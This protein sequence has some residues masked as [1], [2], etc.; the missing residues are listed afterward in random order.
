[1]LV[2]ASGDVAAPEVGLPFIESSPTSREVFPA[3]GGRRSPCSS[4]L[5]VGAPPSWLAAR[6]TSLGGVGSGAA[7]LLSAERAELEGMPGCGVPVAASAFTELNPERRGASPVV[8]WAALPFRAH[9]RASPL[10][11]APLPDMSRELL[12]EGGGC[13]TRSFAL[14]S[15]SGAP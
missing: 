12:S 7:V 3:T 2:P 11:A 4:T 15:W 5:D 10:L 14:R 6:L 9:E 13:T 8:L 1:M